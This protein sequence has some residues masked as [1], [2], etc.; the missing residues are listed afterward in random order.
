MVVGF[1]AINVC[2][3]SYATD[4]T[5]SLKFWGM[6]EVVSN[7]MNLHGEALAVK[8]LAVVCEGRRRQ[9]LSMIWWEIEGFLLDS[10]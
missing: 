8:V 6:R 5:L 2:P 1:V 7:E 4:A 9:L 10:R 3:K